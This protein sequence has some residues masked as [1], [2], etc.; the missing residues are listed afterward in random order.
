MT[1]KKAKAKVETQAHCQCAT[2]RAT[3]KTANEECDFHCEVVRCCKC[4]ICV[5]GYET[6]DELADIELRLSQEVQA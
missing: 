5:I 6:L 2:C 4:H 3:I 1:K